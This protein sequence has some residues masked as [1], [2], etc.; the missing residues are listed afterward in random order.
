MKTNKSPKTLKEYISYWNEWHK[1]W[2]IH[3]DNNVIKE[4]KIPNVF[5]NN[6]HKIN[7]N[8]YYPEPFYIRIKDE[9]PNEID[10]IYIS[11]NPGA[12]GQKQL[13]SIKNND[14]IKDYETYTKNMSTLLSLDPGPKKFVKHRED[15]T[16]ELLDKSHKDNLNILCADLV[17]W[18]T[19]NQMDIQQYILDS[20]SVKNII[21]FVIKP[22]TRI[23]KNQISNNQLKGKIIIRGTSF[24]NVLNL[25]IPT[26]IAESRLINAKNKIK[27]YGIIDKENVLIEK[28]SSLLT[29]V[30]GFGCKYYIFTGGQGMTLPPVDKLCVAINCKEDI[31]TVKELL[32]C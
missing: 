11:I 27:Y 6:S 28:F 15:R 20:N 17:P 24:R 9:V 23:S 26:M 8:D 21:K 14:L 32:T 2:F 4:W 10:A 12:G 19:E 3:D 13:K 1:E 25:V 7:T 16:R 18:H 5:G 30:E 29:I 31:K 22:L